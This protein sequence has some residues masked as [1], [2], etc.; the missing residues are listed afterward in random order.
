MGSISIAFTFLGFGIL[1]SNWGFGN[2]LTKELSRNKNI[3]NKYFSNYILI[4]IFFAFIAILVIYIIV[5]IFSYTKETIAV[6]QIISFSL[7]ATTIDK[8]YFSIF[9][10]FE[11]FKYISIISFITSIIRLGLC[12]L[13][14]LNN[15]TIINIAIIYTI[16]EYVALFISSIIIYKFLP[17]LKFEIKLRFAFSEIIKAVPFFWMGVLIMID[18]RSEILILSW[19]FDE[20][21]VGFYSAVVTIIGGIT[22]FSE[23]IRNAIFPLI[24]RYQKISKSKLKEIVTVIGK[25]ILITTIPISIIIYFLSEEIV[26]LFFG[27][28]FSIS[29]IMLK[30][31]IWSFIFYTLTVVLTGLL[32]SYDQEKLVAISLFVSGTATI[33][34]NILLISIIGVVGVAIV[35]MITSIIIFT[36]CLVIHYKISGYSIINGLT[37]LLM[38]IT[39]IITF[40]TI[41]FIANVNK[42]LAIAIGIIVYLLTLKIFKIIN[43]FDFT[44]WKNVYHEF[45]GKN[46]PS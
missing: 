13:I 6:I 21:T 29:V 33:I 25:Y 45:N 14:M 11:E 5:P 46:H 44:L 41:N 32:I 30:I 42:W 22:L 4:R 12:L 8:L 35:R 20:M 27:S 23:G 7:I 2:L 17:N 38:L 1:F 24:L 34:L 40:F 28:E 31:T 37:C 18:T 15:G 3:Y 26:Y 39:S 19:F 16:T 9:I 43:K 36:I 10:A